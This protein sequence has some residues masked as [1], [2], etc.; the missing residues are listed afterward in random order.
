[1]HYRLADGRCPQEQKLEILGAAGHLA[2][3]RAKLTHT[4]P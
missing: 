3:S 4:T 2:I 1:M